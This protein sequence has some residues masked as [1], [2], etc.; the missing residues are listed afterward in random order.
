MDNDRIRGASTLFDI[1]DPVVRNRMRLYANCE[2]CLFSV[3]ITYVNFESISA[4]YDIAFAHAQTRK[5][6]LAIH[7]M[8]DGEHYDTMRIEFKPKTFTYRAG[9]YFRDNPKTYNI[10]GA[11]ILTSALC[12]NI[13]L[14]KGLKSFSFWCH[15]ISITYWTF[16]FIMEFLVIK[17]RIVRFLK[18]LFRR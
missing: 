12:F 15:N 5:H 6:D 7:C 9:K 11:C 14:F 18:N 16:H 3:D 1:S 4:G 13:F 2:D 8:K 10:L 17:P